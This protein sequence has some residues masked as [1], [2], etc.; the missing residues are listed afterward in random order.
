M[1]INKL[2]SENIKRLSVVEITP[3]GNVVE[4]TGKNGAGKTSVLDSIYWALA[5]QGVIQKSPIRKGQE[6]AKIKLDLGEF[7]V[8]RS[9]AKVENPAAGEKDFTTKVTVTTADGADKKSPQGILDALLGSVCFDPFEFTRMDAKAQFNA[10][11]GFVPDVDFEH[12]AGQ[13]RTDTQLRIDAGRDRDRE[14]AA[15]AVISVPDDTPA[16]MVDEAAL[17]KTLGEAAKHN[18]EIET[19][20]SNREAVAERIKTQ[21]QRAVDLEARAAEIS[22]AGED[23]C[24]RIIEDAKKRVAAV[25]S[26]AV[27][28]AAAAL[29]EGQEQTN[30]ANADQ[31]KLDAAP[32]LPAPIDTDA[33]QAAY[34]AAKTAN[35]N[36][37]RK[38]EKAAH[39]EK[40]DAAASLWDE[41]DARMKARETAKQKAI[42]EAKLP[43][44]GLGFG[45]GAILMNGLPFDQASDAE[46]LRV[47]C[48]IA[49]A[50]NPKLRVIRV[51][52]GSLLDK[53]ALKVLADMC[54]ANDFQ[55][56]LESVDSSSPG[57]V[58]LENG[59]VKAAANE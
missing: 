26:K 32:P 18:S 23:E 41:I 37:R 11:R 25:Q 30:A 3:T 8:T 43:V 56:W 29:L 36:V 9:F 35:V 53:D 22:K 38:L 49:M 34:E 28:E 1:K 42:A 55:C 52:D 50:S 39:Q 45:D 27:A 17:V 13:Q 40:A 12:I 19:R 31:A 54:D 2:I 16:E 46:Q 14:K 21:R 20:K 4:I 44:E 51:R 7:I 10:L 6:S 59:H 48:A 57:A 33:V 58:V 47:S 24:E 5:G 15:A